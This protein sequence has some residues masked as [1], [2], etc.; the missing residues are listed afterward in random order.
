MNAVLSIRTER[1]SI[2]LSFDS[3]DFRFKPGGEYG[4]AA[5]GRYCAVRWL[6]VNALAQRWFPR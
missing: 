5:W 2:A 1:T 4:V 6:G 3:T